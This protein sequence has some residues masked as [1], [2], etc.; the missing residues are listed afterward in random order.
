ML[1][2]KLPE[3]PSE[4]FYGIFPEFPRTVIQLLHAR[5]LRS[6]ESVEHFLN[7]DYH[8]LHDPYLFRD[9]QKACDRIYKAIADGQMIAIHGDYDADGV[10][11][12]VIL[13]SALTKLGGQTLVFPSAVAIDACPKLA[14]RP[15]GPCSAVCLPMKPLIPVIPIVFILHPLLRM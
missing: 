12:S 5:G 8:H 11:G 2:L 6:Q 14:D 3:E 9:M 15:G 13:E 7:P 10:T 4:V 1:R